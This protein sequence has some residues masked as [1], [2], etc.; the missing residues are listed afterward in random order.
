MYEQRLPPEPQ[1]VEML[2]TLSWLRSLPIL[3]AASAP[4]GATA[5]PTATTAKLA[6]ARQP[7]RPQPAAAAP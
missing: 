4:A 3:S 6:A 1:G 2:L 5:K 7:R